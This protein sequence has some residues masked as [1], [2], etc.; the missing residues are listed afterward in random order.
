[1]KSTHK[2]GHPVLSQIVSL[3]PRDIV[4]QVV[5]EYQS[6]YYYK[7]MTTHKHLVFMLYG[8]ISRSRSLRGLCNSILFLENK[9]SYLQIDK[10]PCLSTFSD[11]NKNRSSDVFGQLYYRLYQ[12]YKGYL[13]TNYLKAFL[14]EVDPSQVEVFDSTTISL[15]T[16]IFKN[17]GT[18]AAD[19]SK[20]GG[21]KVNVKTSLASTVPNIVLMDHAST[22]EKKFIGQLSAQEN[23]IYVFDK[24]Y[25]SFWK[26]R[27][28]IEKGAHFLTMANENIQATVLTEQPYPILGPETGEV[29]QDARVMI[30]KTLEGGPFEARMITYK[31][32]PKKPPV[33]FITS[34]FELDVMT[35]VRLYKCRWSIEV[36]F[37]SLKQ[38]FEL[39]HFYSDSP[40]GIKTQIW[41]ALIANLIFRVI[42]KMVNGA[43]SFTS[44][45][46]MA[47]LNLCSYDNLI[48]KIKSMTKQYVEEGLSSVQLDL[49]G[50]QEGVLSEV[51]EKS[52]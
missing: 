4:D 48:Y 47:S 17:A 1:M 16:D 40:E 27:E 20:K 50:N 41:V 30:G 25:A 13:N 19:G 28:M 2:A 22:S 49:F 7:Y 9:L 37:K 35:V 34:L 51:R 43:K 6:D 11:A 29:V 31:E 14:S 5:A 46:I 33:R 3:I 38:N 18:P 52:P 12:H 23:K 45:V 39:Y 24:G 42:H 36:L 8:V 32:G 44:V 26:W 10:A 21:I 15:F